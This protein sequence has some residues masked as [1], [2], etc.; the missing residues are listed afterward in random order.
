MIDMTTHETTHR[1]PAFI[2]GA[3]VASCAAVGDGFVIS[4]LAGNGV[5]RLISL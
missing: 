1:P 4:V 3:R 5:F 2:R